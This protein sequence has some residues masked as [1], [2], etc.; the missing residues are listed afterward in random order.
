MHFVLR[1]VRVIAGE[2]ERGRIRIPGFY[3][4]WVQPTY[5]IVR[6]LIYAFAAVM[7]FPYLPG[8]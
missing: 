8:E 4:E 1:F 7:I 6:I 2:V 5:K 3:P